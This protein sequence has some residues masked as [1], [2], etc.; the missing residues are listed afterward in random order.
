MKKAIINTDILDKVWN[1]WLQQQVLTNHEQAW[2]LG[3]PYGVN[4]RRSNKHARFDDWLFSQ[5]GTIRRINKQFYI[6]FTDA[7]RAAFFILRYS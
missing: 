6:E 4:S 2:T 7:S 3:R 5:G 1:G